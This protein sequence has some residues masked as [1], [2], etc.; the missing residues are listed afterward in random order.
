VLTGEFDAAQLKCLGSERC[1]V[2][3]S[4]GVFQFFNRSASSAEGVFTHLTDTT[5]M[6]PRVSL[7]ANNI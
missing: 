1:Y 3:S 2:T 4:V 6:L 5:M 7:S